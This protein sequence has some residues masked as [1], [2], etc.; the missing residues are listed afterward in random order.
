MVPDTICHDSYFESNLKKRKNITFTTIPMT[1]L[2][3]EKYSNLNDTDKLYGFVST[4]DKAS[5]A[6]KRKILESLI[7]KK[8]N[9]KD[10]ENEDDPN[11]DELIN[12][13]I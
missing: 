4:Y 6:D 11:D 1:F 3:R 8:N 13:A 7:I 5:S 2:F 12:S 9:T 10:Y